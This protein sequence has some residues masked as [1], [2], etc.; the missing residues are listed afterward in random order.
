ML[1]E[2]GYELYYEEKDFHTHLL[3]IRY[4][5]GEDLDWLIEKENFEVLDVR[6]WKEDPFSVIIKKANETPEGSGF[7]IIQYFVP[8]ALINMLE[9]LGYESYID[10][11]SPVEHHIYFYRK[12]EEKGKTRLTKSGRIPLVI[13][14]ATPV[15]YPI[16]MRLLQSKKLMDRIKIEELKIWD[17]TEKHLAW[18]VNGKADISFS[19]V[20]AV[21]NIYQNNL[22][23]K[24]K[25]VTIWDNFYL[26]TQ[27]FQ[28]KDFSEL[29]GNLVWPW[30]VLLRYLLF[31]P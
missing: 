31:L 19:A 23:I 30:P 14:S 4:K 8:S 16:I 9:P 29:K 3:Y 17:K 5:E 6:G 22:D 12:T 21:S 1:Q 2:E 20:A 10:R 27:G 18:I 13:Q 25:A 26:L 24:M 15:V 11:I 28:V 7:R